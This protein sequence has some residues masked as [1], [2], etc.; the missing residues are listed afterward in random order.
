MKIDS[1]AFFHFKTRLKR[2]FIG[3]SVLIIGSPRSG[4][5]WLA[6][7]LNSN[8]DFL[9]IF[10]PF[11]TKHNPHWKPV[12]QQKIYLRRDQA[13]QY[14]KLMKKILLGRIKYNWE[15]GAKI[16]NL[17]ASRT[18]V[19]A[20][21]LN[22]MTPWLQL[23]FPQLKI[24][25]IVR[26]PY[27]VAY[28]L[29]G[30]GWPEEL[31][32]YYLEQKN[33]LDDNLTKQQLELIK[34]SDS[35]FQRYLASWVIENHLILKRTDRTANTTSVFYENLVQ[36]PIKEINRL[37]DFCGIK[38]IRNTT[39]ATF[40]KSALA[41]NESIIDPKN[42]QFGYRWKG[43][44]TKEDQKYAENLLKSFN[45]DWLYKKRNVPAFYQPLDFS[46]PEQIQSSAPYNSSTVQRGASIGSQ[47][48]QA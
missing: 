44:I 35:Q 16:G 3:S 7:I 46:L 14:K 43:N 1:D 20:I 15:K 42:K 4:T 19:K 32:A 11:S 5:T 13:F 41:S 18:L 36:Q 30:Y 45:L 34:Q 12:G 26:D 47:Q 33:L 17:N 28:S 24:I 21:R 8:N 9:Y 22:A 37:T 31:P 27:S 2:H 23:N 38:R 10:E 25:Y 40:R 48:N 6:E 29:A 39:R